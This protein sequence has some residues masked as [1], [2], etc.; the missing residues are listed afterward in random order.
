[1]SFANQWDYVAQAVG[2]NLSNT[3][4]TRVQTDLRDTLLA[5]LGQ[6]F[7]NQDRQDPVDVFLDGYD[8]SPGSLGGNVVMLYPGT[9]LHWDAVAG[10]YQALVAPTLQRA[11][12]AA[13][14]PR[15]DLVVLTPAASTVE[16]ATTMVR[17]S[18]GAQ[19][20]QTLPQ[21]VQVQGTVSLV[22]GVSATDYPATPPGTIPVAAIEV[23]GG[24]LISIIDLRRFP[25]PRGTPMQIMATA[26]IGVGPVI[27]SQYCECHDSIKVGSAPIE[28]VGGGTTGHY[29]LTFRVPPDQTSGIIIPQFLVYRVASTLYWSRAAWT[30]STVG[31]S[32]NGLSEFVVTVKIEDDTGTPV[33]PADGTT[34]TIGAIIQRAN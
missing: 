6:R 33:E 4:L 30:V 12:I 20:I 17:T 32:D 7:T 28:K 8:I 18:T 25:V 16:S 31:G 34:V 2:E 26:A 22:T 9:M 27:T 21:F 3:K 15:W 10:L 24:A 29:S 13:G 14:G 5:L 23:S 11:D 19:A 1:M